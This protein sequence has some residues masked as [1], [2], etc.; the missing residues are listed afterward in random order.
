MHPST[1]SVFGQG[2]VLCPCLHDVLRLVL[3]FRQ[4]SCLL[5]AGREASPCNGRRIEQETENQGAGG[6][7][8]L[9]GNGS[10]ACGL[11]WLGWD[12]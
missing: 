1:V 9:L 6:A 2:E 7:L 8:L 3:A 5:R 11:L 4:L 12:S 10:S